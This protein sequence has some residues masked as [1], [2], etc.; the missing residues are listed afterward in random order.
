MTNQF[1]PDL[2]LDE[3]ELETPETA[4]EELAAATAVHS[5]SELILHG[6]RQGYVSQGEILQ[7]VPQPED[8]IERLEEIYAALQKE[9]I[10]V[11]DDVSEEVAPGADAASSAED[12]AEEIEIDGVGINDTV[13]MYLREIG[14][15]PLLRSDEEIEL[16]LRVERGEFLINKLRDAA[17][18]P[19]NENNAAEL[20]LVLYHR[21]REEWPKI[22]SY[23]KALEPL[24]G[25]MTPE[26][27]QRLAPDLV[28]EID[29]A[30][31]FKQQ[32]GRLPRSLFRQIFRLHSGMLMEP[33]LR[34][35]ISK[36]WRE[37]NNR[38]GFEAD[39]Q[40]DDFITQSI[41]RFDLL[42][43]QI[44]Q[45]ISEAEEWLDDEA[46]IAMITPSCPGAV[47]H[48]EFLL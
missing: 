24:L 43:P 6:K 28:R 30:L 8:E 11:V 37:L 21:L 13:R 2:P 38:Y 42:P 45:H 29:E 16:A 14:F 46:C 35:E 31:A 3:D 19:W 18:V 22:E 47:A 33:K 9:G 40:F 44:Q 32:H 27:K 39:Q 10:R 4:I 25:R 41:I 7:L 23:L 26:H 12:L 15:F 17:P 48:L 36:A 5:L 1:H 20:A 34:D